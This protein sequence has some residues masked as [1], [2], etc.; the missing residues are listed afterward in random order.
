MSTISTLEAKTHLSRYLAE[1]VKRQ[2]FIIT[3]GKL[4]VACLVPL[5]SPQ[6]RPRPKV[7]EMLGKPHEAH[8]AVG[9]PA[10][11][12]FCQLRRLA[13]QKEAIY[14]SGELPLFHGDPFDRLLIAQ[15]QSLAMPVVTPDQPFTPLGVSVIW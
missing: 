11:T 4:P 14:P 9:V 13:L 6:S 2:E 7:C 15:A 12:E 8:R 10:Q 1:V 5:D 3:L